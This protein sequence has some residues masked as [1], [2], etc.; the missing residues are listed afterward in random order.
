MNWVNENAGVVALVTAIIVIALLAVTVAMLFFLKSR[1]AVQRLNFLGFYSRSV[2][3]RKNH[4]ELTFGNR[5]LNDVGIAE[6][7]VSNGKINFDLTQRYREQ[8]GL[9]FEA[10]I[11]VEQR[12]SLHLRLSE[13]EVRRLCV[14][15][16]DGK[17]KVG[18]LRAYAVDL[19]GNL[20]RGRICA[21]RKLL[22][23]LLAEEKAQTAK[24]SEE[25][26]IG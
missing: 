20:Y 11:V 9:S 5:S 3:T 10:R 19:T 24:K 8:S 21:V 17:K 6:L 2:D 12:S 15:L 23:E 25:T 14:E 13:E 18:C 7:G 22:K 1:I 26:H 16:P 4:A